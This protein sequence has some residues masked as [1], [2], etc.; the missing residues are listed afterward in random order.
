MK[1]FDAIDRKRVIFDKC[2]DKE[3]ALTFSA[4]LNGSGG[5]KPNNGDQ[6][7]TQDNYKESG[8]Q[9]LGLPLQSQNN[10]KKVKDFKND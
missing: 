9:V 6:L 10:D 7:R 8:K 5:F 3:G 1:N 4:Q 2:I